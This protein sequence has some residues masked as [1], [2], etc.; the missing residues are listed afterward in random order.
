[1][2]TERR[3]DPA[4]YKAA[5][6][7]R[8]SS[9]KQLVEEDPTILR[10]TT[11]QLNSAL[12]LAALHG[13]A[14]FAREVLGRNRDLLVARNDDGDTPLH[15]A[16]KSGKLEVAKLL[17]DR[18]LTLPP[19]QKSPLI[20]T[21][22]AGNSPLHEAVHH[23]RGAVAVALLDA[24]PLRG[25]D[26]N[27]R[28]ESPLHM[29]ALEGLVNVVQK[30]VDH[31]WVDQEFLPSVSLSGTA[32][33][34]AVLGGH[35]RIVEILLDKRPELIDLTDSDGNNAL[36]YAAQKNHPR[37][38]DMLLNKQSELAYKRNLKNLW[39]PLHM[40]AHYGSTDAIKALLR[41]CPDVAEMVDSYGGNAFHT[42]VTSGKLNALKC[43]LRHVR[44]AELLNRVDHGGNTPLHLAAKMSRVSS[45]LMLLKDS[46]VDPCVRDHDGQTARSLVE[47]KLHTG[48]MDAYE[49]YLWKQLK[50]QESKRCRKQQLPP[51]TAYPS[52]RATNEKYFERIVETYI[53]VATLIATVTFAATFTMPGG[54]D[55]GSGLAIHRHTM[56]FKIFVIS[57]TIA[58]CSSIVVV[59]CFIWAWQDPVKFKVNQL[60]WG[61]RLTVIACLGM[62]VSLMTAV[63]ITVDPHT[64][65]PAYVVIAIGA[66]TPFV[67][68]FMLGREV[69]Y[70]PL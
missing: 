29:A 21:N 61:H 58:M 6:Q 3:M 43:L 66:G 32:L 14:D 15:L 62:L 63:F 60:L 65:W 23:R 36:H 10:A 52:R 37:A 16:A 64:R 68:F 47:L 18:A 40:A 46:R 24:D 5:T 31:A 56:A 42:S 69:I 35:I 20:M 59:F 57:N 7:G 28:M 39:S 67:V 26:Y 4:L 33:H 25:H 19:D 38:V 12:H 13:H 22:K 54:Y 49:M 70:V 50:H 55:N 34:Q 27:E 44:P 8:V 41:H 9:L 53:L 2:E 51:M 30:I 48:E 17:V 11:P 45:A 1:M